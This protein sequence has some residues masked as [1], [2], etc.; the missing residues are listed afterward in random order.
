[1]HISPINISV[2]TTNPQLRVKMMNNRFAGRALSVLERFAQAGIK[3]N[4][5]IVACPGINDGKE[6]DKTLSDLAAFYPAVESIA[7]VPVGLTRYREG[8]YPL[9]AYTKETARQTLAQIE[10]FGDVCRKKH[11]VRIAFASDEFYLQA[12]R[13][14]PPAEF[15]EDFSQLENGV[16][17]LA[18][19]Q[20]QFLTALQEKT[21]D[22]S[23]KRQVTVASGTASAPFLQ[24]LF[25]QMQKKFPG[26][27]ASVAAIENRFFGGGVNVS[28]LV[29]GA[30][31]ISQLKG[32]NLGDALLIPAVMLCRQGDVFL[33][34]VS[35][36]D[37]KRQLT[38]ALITVAND[39]SALLDAVLGTEKQA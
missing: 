30:D 28:G 19:L 8:L 38:T 7:I 12:G 26:V 14:I 16:G 20:E 25:L 32:K 27:S 29:T 34:D 39:G 21:C 1:M 35:I 6:L 3:M 18:L 17:L 36:Q 33:D 9:K 23:L 5:Q 11:G 24:A 37:V 4:C 22:C 10:Q 31:L 15:Y 13:Q 2:H